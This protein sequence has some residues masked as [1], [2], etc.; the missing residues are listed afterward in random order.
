MIN[1]KN[2]GFFISLYGNDGG[3]GSGNFNHEGRPGLVGGS[4]SGGGSGGGSES[5]S[6]QSS[7]GTIF[8]AP[9]MQASPEYQK[10]LDDS[11]AKFKSDDHGKRVTKLVKNGILPF[12]MMGNK[13]DYFDEHDIWRMNM[14]NAGY[15]IPDD[16]SF[17]DACDYAMERYTIMEKY[18]NAHGK[19]KYPEKEPEGVYEYIRNRD[20]RLKAVQYF[21]GVDEVE[22]NKM[23]EGLEGH[24]GD[25]FANSEWVDKY[26]DANGRYDKPIYRWKGYT[27]QEAIDKLK[28][29]FPGAK[30]ENKYDSNWSFS[31]DPFAT[32]VFGSLGHEGYTT[33]CYVCKNPR[34]AAPIAQYSVYED[35]YEV[36]PH[37]KTTYTVQAI[38]QKEH[39]GKPYW[40]VEISEDDWQAKKGIE[41]YDPPR[42]SE[43]HNKKY[44]WWGD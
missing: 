42:E 26:I 6:K 22:A 20:N 41:P 7:V 37:S 16:M 44:D 38:R 27:G 25:A 17:E 8:H 24:C 5:G 34:T 18:T 14:K 28:S 33:F 35:E 12:Y 36:V 10:E 21:T 19:T 3:E 9:H 4:G 13:R 30:M 39:E 32:S 29:L 15:D 31:A 23:L 1:E 43:K 2:N 11:L 40:E